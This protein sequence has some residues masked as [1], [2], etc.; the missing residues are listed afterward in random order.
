MLRVKSWST[1]L[2]SSLILMSLLTAKLY[3]QSTDATQNS[4]SPKAEPVSISTLEMA[5]QKEYVFLTGQKRLLEERLARQAQLQEQNLRSVEAEINRLQ[6]KQLSLTEERQRFEGIKE[7]IEQDSYSFNEQKMNL[8]TTLLQ[9]QSTLGELTPASMELAHEDQALGEQLVTNIEAATQILAGLSKVKT[10]DGQ[11]FDQDGKLVSG[12]ITKIGQLAAFGQSESAAGALV[13]SGA[14]H[15]KIVDK[16]VEEPIAPLKQQQGPIYNV[17]LFDPSTKDVPAKSSKTLMQ[18]LDAGGAIGWVITGLGVIALLT[19]LLKGWVLRRFYVQHQS[20]S[21]RLSD[22]LNQ[23]D[24][25][26]LLGLCRRIGGGTAKLVSLAVEHRSK[27]REQFEDIISESY[28]EE[29]HTLDRFST[30][31]LVV[32]AIAPLLGLLGTVTGMISTFDIITEVGTGDPKMLSGGIS[33]ALVT[34]MLGLIVAIPTLLLGNMLSGWAETLKADV[35]KV[36]LQV[37]NRF[38]KA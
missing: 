22:F 3:A 38:G 32:A 13:P 6:S 9:T 37:S 26:G 23:Q 16:E 33:E 7:T 21:S 5:Y 25:E 34:T 31:I 11:F 35:E 14:E 30:F 17:F 28:I 1:W 24:T 4:A 2:S 15:L 19:I 29:T 12:K 20:I 10:E 18:T 27:N 36:I 8:E